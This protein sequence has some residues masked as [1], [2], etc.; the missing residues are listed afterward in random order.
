MA[1]VELGQFDINLATPLNFA[2]GAFWSGL[3]RIANPPSARLLMISDTLEPQDVMKGFRR[4]SPPE[5]ELLPGVRAY[6]MQYEDFLGQTAQEVRY[7]RTYLITETY[8]GDEGLV[9][10]LGTYGIPAWKV[11]DPVPQ[12]FISG[13]NNWTEIVTNSGQHF[14]LLRNKEQQACFLYPRA[15][16]RLFGLEFPIFAAL[17]IYAFSTQDALKTM[18]VK[19]VAAKYDKSQGDGA[20]EARDILDT[21]TALQQEMNRYGAALHTMRLYVMA[22]GNSAEELKQRLDIISGSLPVDMERTPAGEAKTIFSATAPRTSGGAVLST[23]GVAILTGSA[24][25]YRRR[26]ESRGVLLGTD[27]NQSPVIFNYFDDRNP[28]YN[29]VVLGQTGGGKTF[30]MLLVMMRH[31]LLGVKGIIIDPQGN[32]DLS[33]LGDQYHKATLGTKGASINILDITRGELRG[34]FK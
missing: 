3:S 6:R 34:C 21:I 19:G 9:N 22:G 26:T 14:G 15:I 1:I 12:P 30:A 4:V 32:I 23:P 8:L 20:A 25:S 10:L 24:L 16:H 18:R 13:Q 29:N 2:T 5:E 17:D 28:S 11:T 7:I 27:Q 33:F 31:M